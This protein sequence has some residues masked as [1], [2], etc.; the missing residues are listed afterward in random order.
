MAS[1]CG[2]WAPPT[3]SAI[4]RRPALLACAAPSRPNRLRHP[5]G[6]RPRHAA[7]VLQSRHKTSTNEF[8]DAYRTLSKEHIPTPTGSTTDSSNCSRHGGTQKGVGA[9]ALAPQRTRAKAYRLDRARLRERDGFFP[10]TRKEQDARR[11]AAGSHLCWLPFSSARD[12]GQHWPRRPPDGNRG[13]ARSTL[14]APSPS[15]P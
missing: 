2:T 8:Y 12:F 13:A 14:G 9:R 10:G 5:A 4:P 15:L 7:D 1:G 11:I 3:W 6:A